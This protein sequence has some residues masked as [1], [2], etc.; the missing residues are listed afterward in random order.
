MNKL[1]TVNEA[2]AKIEQLDSLNN[3]YLIGYNKFEAELEATQKIPEDQRKFFINYKLN[4]DLEGE[5]VDEE[6]VIIKN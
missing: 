3:I 2:R 6:E 5:P 1:K 4:D